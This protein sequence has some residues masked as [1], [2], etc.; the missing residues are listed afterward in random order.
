MRFGELFPELILTLEIARNTV[1]RRRRAS[2]RG[3]P[4]DALE[5]VPVAW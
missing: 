3:F 2:V 5:L 4:L 1:A